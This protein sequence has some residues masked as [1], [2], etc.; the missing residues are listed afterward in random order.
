MKRANVGSRLA[1]LIPTLLGAPLRA[2]DAQPAPPLETVNA[3]FDDYLRS[4]EPSAALTV[5]ALRAGW[6]STYQTAAPESFI[7]DA[8]AQLH[9]D[10]AVA[11]AAFD[12]DSIAEAEASVQPLLAHADPYVQA[13]AAYLYLRVLAAQG[14]F[15][16]LDA[17]LA[18]DPQR[19]TQIEHYSPF[20]ASA[21]LLQGLARAKTLRDDPAAASLTQLAARYPSLPGALRLEARQLRLEI[22]RRERG[23]LGEV[24]SMMTYLAD[25]LAARDVGDKVKS[26]QADVLALLDKLIDQTQQQEQQARSQSQAQGGARS[27]QAPSD[28][29]QPKTESS[30][31]EGAGRIGDLGAMPKTSPAEMWGKLPPAERERIL[32]SLR[33]RYPSRYR[34]LVEQYYR[35]LAEEK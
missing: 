2:Q 34:E 32:Q 30:A 31:P 26:R 14:R 20:G 13:N 21:H 7:P 11:L 29:Q 22:E 16:E 5:A 28:P 24:A 4:M 12:A 9:A 3:R 27:G 1:L 17:W 23:N 15:E 33:E 6:S 10:F 19:I 18:G 25:R 8:L 35:S